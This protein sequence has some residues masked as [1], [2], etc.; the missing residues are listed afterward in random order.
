MRQIGLVVIFAF[1][2]CATTSSKVTP[3]GGNRYMVAAS[4]NTKASEADTEQKAVEDAAQTCA[5]Q[6][7]RLVLDQTRTHSA[8]VASA[9]LNSFGGYSHQHEKPSSVLYFRCE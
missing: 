8:V 6:D 1:V 4:G 2:A 5:K 7:K 3:L 9:N